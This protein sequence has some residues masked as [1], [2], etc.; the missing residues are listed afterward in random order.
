MGEETYAL[1]LLTGKDNPV[2]Q[3]LYKKCGFEPAG[4]IRDAFI[5]KG[6]VQIAMTRILQPDKI[7]PHGAL[8]TKEK[9]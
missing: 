5:G 1:Y 8:W 2:G 4:E 3:R 9:K 7:Y 6:D